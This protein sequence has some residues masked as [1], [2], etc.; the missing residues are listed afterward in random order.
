MS[1]T[2]KTAK[3]IAA[4][5]ASLLLAVAAIALVATGESESKAAPSLAA[6]RIEV[7]VD[8]SDKIDAFTTDAKAHVEISAKDDEGAYVEFDRS[9]GYAAGSGYY[10]L[11][12]YSIR[13]RSCD[14]YGG[15]SDW[16]TASFDVNNS[17]PTS[18]S[19]DVNVNYSRAINKFSPQCMVWADVTPSGASAS[20]TGDSIRYEYAD[21]G[22]CP[23]AYYG[24]GDHLIK[25][26]AVDEFGAASP[27][28]E[29][30]FSVGQSSAPIMHLASPDIEEGSSHIDGTSADVEWGVSVSSD[31]DSRVE[32]MVDYYDEVPLMLSET[33][34]AEG[35]A[36]FSSNHYGMGR[37][38]AAAKVT[39]LFGQV[40]FAYK[41][42]VVTPLERSD[43][44]PL[45][46]GKVSLESGE[47]VDVMWGTLEAGAAIAD[48]GTVLAYINDF[49]FEVLGQLDH[50]NETD[51]LQIYGLT[52][53]G[54]WELIMSTGPVI[55]AK[56]EWLQHQVNGDMYIHVFGEGGLATVTGFI[57]PTTKFNYDVNKYVDMRFVYSSQHVGCLQT[58]VQESGLAMTVN[59]TVIDASDKLAEIWASKVDEEPML[60][61]YA[62]HSVNGEDANTLPRE[63]RA[64]DTIR[65]AITVTN[66]STVAVSGATVEE[67]F[68]GD[69]FEVV[70]ATDGYSQGKWENVSFEPGESKTFE[71]DLRFA[72]DSAKYA[73]EKGIGSATARVGDA[74][75]AGN[76]LE[77]SWRTP[78]SLTLA[79]TQS[80]SRLVSGKVEKTP[81]GTETREV[82]S[83]DVVSYMITATNPGDATCYDVTIELAIPTGME[84]ITS[85]APGKA[86]GSK[87][88]WEIGDVPAK[89]QRSVSVVARIQDGASSMT[90]VSAPSVRFTQSSYATGEARANSCTLTK[91]GAPGISADIAQKSSGQYGTADITGLLRGESLSYRV[92]VRNDGEGEA[93]DVNVVLS[94]LANLEDVTCT[95][96]GASWD[97][98]SGSVSVSLGTVAPAAVRVI[99]VSGKVPAS[100]DAKTYA[101]SAKVTYSA[102]GSVSSM[103]ASTS[104]VRAYTAG[105]TSVTLSL[106]KAI[107]GRMS[108]ASTAEV[109]AG[110]T[111]SYTASV[112]GPVP[113]RPAA[114]EVVLEASA[115][116]SL[117][118]DPDSISITKV[119]ADG[120]WTKLDASSMASLS[121]NPEENGADGRAMITAN[122]G[123]LSSNEKVLLGFDVTIPATDEKVVYECSAK[124]TYKDPNY[125][126]DAKVAGP[127][128]QSVAKDGPAS[129]TPTSVHGTDVESL[130]A[131][132]VIVTSGDVVKVNTRLLNQADGAARDVEVRVKVPEGLS[133]SSSYMGFGA[134]SAPESSGHIDYDIRVE[135]DEIVA[136]VSNVPAGHTGI[137]SYSFNIPEDNQ[138]GTWTTQAVV[139]Y[140]DSNKGE[141]EVAEANELVISQ[142]V[143]EEPLVETGS[144]PEETP[145]P[146]PESEVEAA[147]ETVA[148]IVQ[149]GE[150]VT[151]AIATLVASIIMA[152][153]YRTIRRRR[154]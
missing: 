111:V 56:P 77:L 123:T 134:L 138:E 152:G 93:R 80:V 43:E 105:A 60:S 49:D 27:W 84:I 150:F 70:R 139:S 25:V 40:A 90:Y 153:A 116:A 118:V 8:Y 37:H 68:S 64:T 44:V 143:K 140:T 95:V 91:A 12:H 5:V 33:V 104:E 50:T 32:L 15:Y 148:E 41:F 82:A 22:N 81:F 46:E 48:D 120:S 74:T 66:P 112:T 107:N 21:E 103:S 146:A 92:I 96:A 26:R 73:Q 113:G 106:E 19:I 69:G 127:I 137:V 108:N 54:E 6:P 97:E 151:G 9:S 87:V 65:H 62:T 94:G 110:D 99:E 98:K 100:T 154:A 147:P 28:V 109:C 75:F 126:A 144:E 79:Q 136:N 31:A 129:L 124:A 55:P 57:S 11:G 117:G 119:G 35:V 115:P 38:M 34:P 16:A 14:G 24:L 128:S 2:T 121:G 53:D 89:A 59:Y 83:G 101:A 145:E 122:I 1:L 42:F 61:V 13:A 10:G 67:S 30:T 18:P 23:S 3:V 4:A 133:V 29:S 47:E 45:T 132:E 149:T 20:D 63:I 125:P 78:S 17:A 36:R 39:D 85:S 52:Q 58:V 76:E 71:I 7:S 141:P 135:G 51:E 114:R 131:D 86:S 142:V 72:P 88:T 130:T 102:A